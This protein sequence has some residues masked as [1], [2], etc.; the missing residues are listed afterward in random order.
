MTRLVDVFAVFVDDSAWAA[1]SAVRG[2][3]GRGDSCSS[4]GRCVTEEQAEGGGGAVVSARDSCEGHGAIRVG[5]R[6]DEAQEI[7]GHEVLRGKREAGGER[8]R[9]REEDERLRVVGEWRFMAS[10]VEGGGAR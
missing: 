8:G 3:E 5:R 2:R 9:E 10:E 1:V 7:R 6:G 4:S